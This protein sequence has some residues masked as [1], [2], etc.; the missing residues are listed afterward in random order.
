[1]KIEKGGKVKD[2]E[3]KLILNRLFDKGLLPYD[4]QYINDTTLKELTLREMEILNEEIEKSFAPTRE[5]SFSKLGSWTKNLI[6][7]AKGR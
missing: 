3:R 4:G 6:K 7:S 5:L 2:E 1:M